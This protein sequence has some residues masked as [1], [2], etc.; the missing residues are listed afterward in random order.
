MKI[1]FITSTRLGDVVLST[2]I[3]NHLVTHSVDPEVTVVCGPLG[4]TIFED[5]PGL[6][7]IIAVKKEPYAGHWRKIWK[8]VWTTRW[9]IV[10][11]LRDSAVSRLIFAKKRYIWGKKN[12][13]EHH[14]VEQNAEVLEVSPIPT[15]HIW[16]GDELAKKAAEL[17]PDGDAPV[18]A[19]G[20]TANWPAKTWPAQNFIDLINRL[21]ET[22]S[23][24][25]VLADAR[26]AVFAAPGEEEAAYEVLNSVP[27]ARRI[28]L[29]AKTT[30]AEAAACLKRCAYYVG[31]DSG[32]MH[33]AAAVDIPVM[34]LF[35]P[36]F[37]HLYRP[38]GVHCDFAQTPETFDELIDYEGYTPQSVKDS[39]MK[40]LTVENVYL[41]ISDHWKRLI[42][43]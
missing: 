17:I 16:I 26:I 11:D 24:G 38:W 27:E 13:K 37:P 1:L 4:K 12:N 14:K 10:V 25:A 6:K 9:D 20:P 34:G 31:N 40:S 42:S 21:T 19:V 5:M 29:I 41:A 30:P 3:L 2:G 18:L 36:S 7:E 8:R 39:L 22:D 33:C 23:D 35:G 28:D 43:E 15:P 32:L